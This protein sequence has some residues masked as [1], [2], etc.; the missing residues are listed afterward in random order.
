MNTL[1]IGVF[2]SG[3][4]GLTVLHEVLKVLPAEDYLFYA[5]TQH[6]PYGEK[7]KDEVRQYI[8]DAVD[9]LA[10]QHIKALV[11]A[12]NTATSIAVNDLRQRYDFPILGIEPAVKPAVQNSMIKH[13]KVLVL[14]TTLTI[15]EEKFQNLVRSID[16]AD[17]VESLALPGLVQLAEKRQFAEAEVQSYLQQALAGLDLNQYGTIVLGCT[18]FPYFRE[19]LHHFF[20]EEV[21]IIDGGEGTARNLYRILQQR[22]QIGEGTGQISYIESGQIIHDAERLNNY[23]QLLLRLSASSTF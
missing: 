16:T 18:H 19:H 11:I 8:F 23:D 15:R 10:A 1:K 7:P 12:C 2:D 21:D 20:P 17:I 3:I 5:D 13:K 22:S 4:G 9:N 6:V 14:A